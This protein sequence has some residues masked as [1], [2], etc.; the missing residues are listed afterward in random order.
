MVKQKHP[1]CTLGFG[2]KE[3]W[4]S[5]IPLF[6]KQTRSNLFKL[7]LL[8]RSNNTMY[9]SNERLPRFPIVH[10][11]SAGGCAYKCPGSTKVSS[12]LSSL[13]AFQEPTP[14]GVLFNLNWGVLNAV[15]KQLVRQWYLRCIKLWCEAAGG[16]KK[17][18]KF[19][20]D[21][22]VVVVV[23]QL[24]RYKYALN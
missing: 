16:K 11:R 24:D 5:S 1:N 23:Y 2:S 3:N 8:L 6:T 20:Q 19:N 17:T 7:L 22:A 4:F 15:G 14:S 13:W 9:H 12:K 21:S 10:L 18:V